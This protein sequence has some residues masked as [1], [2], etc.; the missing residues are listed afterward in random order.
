[1]RKGDLNL[2]ITCPSRCSSRF[3]KSIF[4]VHPTLVG[5]SFS[6]RITAFNLFHSFWT[7]SGSSAFMYTLLN[8]SPLLLRFCL[9]LR[10]SFR[11]A[12][13]FVTTRRGQLR[14]S[15]SFFLP[16]LDTFTGT[17][18]LHPTIS[19]IRFTFSASLPSLS[20]ACS[21]TP[22]I[23]TFVSLSSWH[24]LGQDIVDGS[25]LFVQLVQSFSLLLRRVLI[26]YRYQHY[27][28]LQPRFRL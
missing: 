23:M 20:S 3:L 6:F 11:D 27:Y 14:S 22:V 24:P 5:A 19:R 10:I 26:C 8:S 21:L 25:G 4:I 17:T 1:M 7:Q 2:S 15:P 12:F 28:L 18:V 16:I 9:F 13:E